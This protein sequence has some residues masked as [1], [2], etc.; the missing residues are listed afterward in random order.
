[1]ED[2]LEVYH[3]PPDENCPLVCMDEQ[4]VQLLKETRVP[5]PA[6]PGRP[7]IYDY[8]YERN[9][10]ANIFMFVAPLIG[11]RCVNV[12]ERRTKQDWA[13]QIREMVDV[14]FPDADK[15]R[16]VMD[17][18]NTHK[19]SSLYQTFPPEE[20]LRL[21]GKLEIH[22]TPKHGSWL[23]I[24]ECELSV[25]TRQCLGRRVPDRGTLH[26]E[27]KAWEKDRNSSQMTVDWQFRTK[28]ARVKLR[29]LYPKL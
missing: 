24:A 14:H 19:I 2:V 21:A 1:M 15:I 22:C 11:W 23:N 18:L 13:T 20:A 5:L 16:L 4:P 12:T 10:T 6:E 25:F 7:A 28:D 17:N 29:S 27:A 8:E 26:E 9:G 3:L